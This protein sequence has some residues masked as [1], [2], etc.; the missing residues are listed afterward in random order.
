MKLRKNYR[1]PRKTVK[2]RLLRARRK[3]QR[4]LDAKLCDVLL[5]TFTFAGSDCDAL[6]E[7]VLA[8]FIANGRATKLILSLEHIRGK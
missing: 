2:T 5:D 3:L 6:T 7:R 1:S 8:A 4:E